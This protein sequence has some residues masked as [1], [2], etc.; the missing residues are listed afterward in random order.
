MKKD[1]MN[2]LWRLIVMAI[3]CLPILCYGQREIKTINDSWKFKKGG[4]LHAFDKV[5]NDQK[6][7]TISVPHTWNTDAYTSK[8]YYKGIGW[9][10]RTLSIPQTWKNKQI[11]LKLDAASKAARVYVNGVFVG[12]H[13]GGYTA[14]IMDIT[15]Y[16][17]FS[18][19]N[20]IAIEVDNSRTDIPPI[21]GDFTFFGGI[22]RDTWIMAVSKQHFDL[23]NG[24]SEG[25]F[26]Q[27]PQ[28][29]EKE[30]ALV[31][32][33]KVVNEVTQNG[34]VFVKH[35]IYDPANQVV[36]TIRQ[37]INLKGQQTN[38]FNSKLIVK[39]PKLWSPENPFLYKIETELIDAQTNKILDKIENNTGFR[40]FNFD[41]EKGFFLNGRPYKLHGICRH[42]DQEP[43]GVAMSD[44]MHRRDMLMIK[45]MGANFIRISHYPQDE[46]ILEQCD[47]LGILA[48][49]EIPVIDIVPDSPQYADVAE[50]NL[51]EMI[52]QHYNHPSIIMWGYMNEI[53]LVTLRKYKEE[54]ELKPVIQR[55][56]N[57][58]KRLEKTLKEE[59]PFRKSVM[60]FHSSNMYNESGLSD[61]SDVIGWNLYSG[62][63]G[64]KLTDFD[65]NL[66]EQHKKYP[67]HPFI[68][69]EYG[70]GSD[71]RLHSF[72]PVNFD[73]SVEY[74]QEYLEHYL[75]AMEERPFVC[76]GT[77]WNFIDF[78]SA[79]RDESMPRI[80]NKGL[81]YSNRVPKD[82]FYYFKA[83]FSKE[84]PVL[85]I[86]VRDWSDRAGIQQ[87]DNPAI[88]PVK[89]YTNLTEVELFIDGKSLGTKSSKNCTVSFDV[90]FTKGSHFLRATAKS[91]DKILEDGMNINFTTIP[92]ALTEQTLK[93][94]ELAVNVGSN[95]FYVNDD[96]KLNWVPDRPYA[97]GSWGY[98]DESKTSIQ[99]STQTEILNT[100][101]NPLYQT[102]RSNLEGYRFDVPAGK[103]ELE[104]LFADTFKETD[105]SPYQLG[106]SVSITNKE[107]CFNIYINQNK[108]EDTFSPENQIGYFQAIKKRYIV[109]VANQGLEVKF[110]KLYGKCFLNGIKLRKLQ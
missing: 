96:S 31:I 54:T 45:D 93:D 72:S 67:Q 71:K 55:T 52:R 53:L 78:S 109:E 64:G 98:L 30:A 99:S 108:V 46:A 74:Q 27:T 69:S 65:K 48:W 35:T 38:E 26:L 68:V 1:K 43:M 77:H 103:Y 62:W 15:Q 87:G 37:T 29:S 100:R 58:A 42:Q 28:V 94:T 33:G 34:K 22:Y 83:F 107:N 21:S 63:Y 2:I 44:E 17:S 82:V 4:K 86:A 7:Q 47:K 90:P 19:E 14:F 84:N 13:L 12:E 76:G 95:C 70:A 3:S 25:V 104:L 85:H 20:S 24:G 75:P 8:E 66:D 60:A 50:K 91:N 92:D 88:Q 41:P 49:E 97:T 23:S 73:F 105:K 102:S 89:V 56:L 81:A 10:R 110:E 61:V 51:R 101:D 40:W 11:F 5:Y 79:L 39:Q 6:W 57:L 36:E 59:D 9:Y 18:S 106:Q 80:N 32:K 16:C